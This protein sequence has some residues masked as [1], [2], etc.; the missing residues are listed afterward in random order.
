MNYLCDQRS[1][2]EETV[3]DVQLAF[4]AIAATYGTAID[5]LGFLLFT[6]RIIH[7]L[8]HFYINMVLQRLLSTCQRLIRSPLA[9]TS[10][11]L[12]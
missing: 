10:R 6:I 5:Q 9:P 4:R 8:T 1:R 12:L 3:D 7:M 11:E 2:C